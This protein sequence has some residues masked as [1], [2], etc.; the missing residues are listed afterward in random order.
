MDEATKLDGVDALFLHLGRRPQSPTPGSATPRS[1]PGSSPHS[2]HA[3][4]D[5]D[6]GNIIDSPPRLSRR[7]SFDVEGA[8]NRL[9]RHTVG[10]ASPYDSKRRSKSKPRSHRGDFKPVGLNEI[11]R[12]VSASFV[13]IRQ[14]ADGARSRYMH[15][16]KIL[17]NP[18]DHENL[19][20]LLPL[21]ASSSSQ[22]LGVSEAVIGHL[23]RLFTRLSSTTIHA[24]RKKGRS[25]ECNEETMAESTRLVEELRAALDS[26]KM[27]K[28]LIVIEPFRTLFDYTLPPANLS[29]SHSA[30][31]WA[32][33][34]QF[35]LL[36]FASTLLRL[37]EITFEIEKKR[38]RFKLFT[39][40]WRKMRFRE[41]HSE[42]HDEQDDI[43]DEATNSRNPDFD[44]KPSRLSSVQVIAIQ[45]HRI[46][47]FLSS[48]SFLFACKGGAI[49]ALLSVTAV[50]TPAS[51]SFF[52]RNRGIWTIIVHPS[53]S[54][55]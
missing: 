44:S 27:D 28:R 32:F 8:S 26:F 2:R 24:L 42:E 11:S 53:H 4:F 41:E 39:P 13:V 18:L 21:L 14:I 6:R 10:S 52:Y 25:G 50:A 15:L 29:P 1:R 36:S 9:E 5:E 54:K 35:S 19:E 38:K 43:V 34:Y 20:T 23:V 48:S 46:A 3:S 22:L 37:L 30:M 40:V 49:V 16:E 51:A 7:K 47:Q 31:Y 33:S 17:Q 12:S 45:F 55:R